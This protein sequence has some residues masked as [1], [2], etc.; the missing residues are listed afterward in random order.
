MSTEA[1]FAM[2]HSAISRAPG[3]QGF[4]VDDLIPVADDLFER[5]PTKKLLRICDRPLQKLI[6]SNRSAFVLRSLFSCVTNFDFVN[7]V[8]FSFLLKAIF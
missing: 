8:A 1:D 3:K 5:L 2:L 4:P 7:F 6:L